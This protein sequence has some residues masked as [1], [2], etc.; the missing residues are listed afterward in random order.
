ML[1]Q[2]PPP[3]RDRRDEM[4]VNSMPTMPRGP[5]MEPLRSENPGPTR[6][7]EMFQPSQSSRQS[8]NQVQDPNYGRLNAP[9][10]P[11]PSGPRSKYHSRM[12]SGR[13]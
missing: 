13:D 2:G 10:E 7:R 6:G 1:P 3:G 12:H 8:H 4:S 9:S 11:T 5:R